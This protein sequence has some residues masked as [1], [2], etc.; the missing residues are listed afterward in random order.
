MV[1]NISRDLGYALEEAIKRH[2]AEGVL[3]ECKRE[4]IWEGVCQPL[5]DVTLFQLAKYVIEGFDF[6]KTTEDLISQFAEWFSSYNE[7]VSLPTSNSSYKRG[8]RDTL[9][10]IEAKLEQLNL[11]EMDYGSLRWIGREVQGG[12]SYAKGNE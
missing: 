9:K 5:N 12:G 2:G 1:H 4:H 11:I 8:R 7:H 10:A 3:E 6:P